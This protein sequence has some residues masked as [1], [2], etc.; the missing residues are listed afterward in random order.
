MTPERIAGLFTREDGSFLC[1][2]WGRPAAPVVFG[3]ADQTLDIFRDVLRAGFG[4]AGHPVT[5]TD[6]EMGS[7]MMLFFMHDWDELTGLPDLDRL[8]GMPDLPTRLAGLRAD[9]YRIFRFDPDGGIRACLTF[10]RMGGTLKGAHPAQLAEALVMNS[11]LTFAH[12]VTPAP[13]LAALIRAAYD[14]VL[15]VA[16]T[17][18]AHA[19]RLSARL[20]RGVS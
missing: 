16:A 11:L 4:H 14:P 1:A 7:N 8:T 19:L 12:D 20:A 17:D 5:D 9:R 15:A 2:K 13:D 10:T 18:P 6:P 3:L